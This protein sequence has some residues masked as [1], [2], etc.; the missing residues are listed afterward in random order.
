M[1]GDL[2]CLPS[3][4][5]SRDPKRNP[6]ARGGKRTSNLGYRESNPGLMSA[7][8]FLE[9]R[10]ID[11]TATPYPICGRDW[12]PTGIVGELGL[13]MVFSS[14]RVFS[15]WV[16]GHSFFGA[17]PATPTLAI[18][19]LTLFRSAH[20]PWPTPPDHHGCDVVQS[21]AGQLS[22]L[23]PDF[24]HHHTPSPPWT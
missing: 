23:I 6:F 11:V 17:Q 21:P 2:C 16:R 13:E 18:P 19:S 10:V 20:S 24:N 22:R 12:F 3:L 1:Q 14:R 4:S 15:W 8:H 9:M 7:F 5:S